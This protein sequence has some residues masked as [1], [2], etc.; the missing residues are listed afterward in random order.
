MSLFQNIISS[1]QYCNDLLI[2][3]Q[4]WLIIA[5]PHPTQLSKL[6]STLL[7]SD[8]PETQ[9]LSYI[10]LKTFQWLPGIKLPNLWHRTESLE[11]CNQ[12]ILAPGSLKMPYSLTYSTFPCAFPSAGKLLFPL[13]SQLWS[14]FRSQLVVTSSGKL[15]PTSRTEQIP[16]QNRFPY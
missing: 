1:Q 9:I 16:W 10:C 4:P 3:Q 15:S 12:P 14:V 6:F 11:V 5:A 7:Q 13:T 8:L 2:N